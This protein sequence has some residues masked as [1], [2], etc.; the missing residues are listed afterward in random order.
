MP[1]LGTF[2][3]EECL[4]LLKSWG[5]S[6]IVVGSQAYDA[7]WGDQPRQTWDSVRTQIES[8]SRLR[9]VSIARDEPFWRDERI[10]GVI[11]GNPP[12]TP[13]LVDKIYIYELQ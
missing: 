6:H 5:V 12:V 13:I 7:G 9:L 11:Y 3:S 2:P 4:A 8:S 1:V 10:S